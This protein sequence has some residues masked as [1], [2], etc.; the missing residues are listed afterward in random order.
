MT[1]VGKEHYNFDRYCHFDRWA[2]YYYQLREVLSLTPTS[3]LEIGIGDRVFGNY[4]TQNTGIAYKTLDIAQDLKPDFVGSITAMPFKDGAYDVVCAFE[5]LEHLPFDQFEKGLSEIKRVA[6]RYAII[7]LPHFGPPVKASFKMPFIK[8]M[9]GA[10]KI[11]YPQKHIFNGQ[12]YWE[13]GKRGYAPKKIRE[14]IKKHFT[15]VKEFVPFE[16]QYHHFY[17]LKK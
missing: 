13:I 11:P 5:V 8:E 12:H 16:N 3:V 9:K 10:W 1:H 15:L 4:I 17:I 14:I 7:S 6:H 2:S